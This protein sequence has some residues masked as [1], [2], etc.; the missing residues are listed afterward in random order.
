MEM[1]IEAFL[2]ECESA[3]FKKLIAFLLNFLNPGSGIRH[4]YNNN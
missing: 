4:K 1:F 2:E 3:A